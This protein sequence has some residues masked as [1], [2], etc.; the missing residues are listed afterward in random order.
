MYGGEK[1]QVSEE[2]GS[3]VLRNHTDV[4]L[5]GYNGQRVGSESKGKTG[6]SALFGQRKD[7][8]HGKHHIPS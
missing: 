4:C 2:T 8:P 6:M 3:V 5:K 7:S 1:K